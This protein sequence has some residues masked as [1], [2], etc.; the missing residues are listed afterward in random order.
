[1]SETRAARGSV[2]FGAWLLKLV[3]FVAAAVVYL[4]G[5]ALVALW[6]SIHKPRPWRPRRIVMMLAADS[7]ERHLH[8]NSRPLLEHIFSRETTRYTVVLYVGD[9]RPGVTRASR[10]VI[11]VDVRIPDWARSRSLPRLV[12]LV[13]RETWGLV[14]AYRLAK[15]IRI[16]AVEAWAPSGLVPRGTLLKWLLPIKLVTQVRGNA[17][18]IRHM[19]G[20]PIYL[21][22][23]PGRFG[24]ITAN[25]FDKF[26]LLLF[27]RACDLVTGMNVNNLE[28]AIAAGADPARTR[29][30]RIVIDPAALN[31]P[32]VE[33]DQLEGFPPA[34]RVVSMWCRLAPDKLVSE[35]VDAMCEV[36]AARPDVHFVL[37]GDG[38]LRE[39]LEE[40]VRAAGH[41]RN[42][43]LVGYRNRA[44][45]RSAARYSDVVIV[46]L[47]GSS[48]IEASAWG[49]PIVAFAIEWHGEVIRPGDTGYIADY[50]D[51][52]DLAR[53][54]IRALDRPEEAERF[55]QACSELTGRMFDPATAKADE[56]RAWRH[57]FPNAES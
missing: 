2:G 6:A 19:V 5:Y 34:G 52:H 25:L 4:G 16:M 37:I 39:S 28:S 32:V 47:G 1:M 57:F 41:E 50:P 21:P 35:G 43:H 3:A 17:D 24:A 44:Y 31:P 26:I 48:L 9:C 15:R 30:Q 54:I 36:I 33:R 20:K 23:L 11:G 27:Y 14:A 7:M 53:Q 42:I 55:A 18:L 8:F 12:R 29:L 13:V 40:R 51:T 45:I 10:H 56:E 46:T 49:R 38:P 22:L